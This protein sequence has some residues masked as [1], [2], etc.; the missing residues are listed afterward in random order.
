[1]STTLERRFEPNIRRS[2]F[3]IVWYPLAFWAFSAATSVLALPRVLLMP[4]ERRTTWVS[5]DRGLR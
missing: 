4:R 5:P 1:M 2:L 3:W